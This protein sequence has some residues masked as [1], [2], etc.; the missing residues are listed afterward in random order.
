M[1]CPQEHF[2]WM[3]TVLFLRAAGVAQT[4]TGR[5]ASWDDVSVTAMTLS[6]FVVHVSI[7]Q[8]ML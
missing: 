3:L 5:E 7:A 6:V 1:A 2:F 8:I 4:H